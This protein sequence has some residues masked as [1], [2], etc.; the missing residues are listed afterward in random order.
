MKLAW[1]NGDRFFGTQDIEIQQI[2]PVKMKNYCPKGA[3][4]CHDLYDVG[5]S[6][7]RVCDPF[8]NQ[9]IF[10]ET[11][12]HELLHAF[13][14]N[15]NHETPLVPRNE[16]REDDVPVIHTKSISSFYDLNLHELGLKARNFIEVEIVT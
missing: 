10:N 5:K 16:T 9:E 13:C 2:D 12:S 11:I 6:M 3:L 15:D 14:G 7:I 8:D 4:G 1:Q